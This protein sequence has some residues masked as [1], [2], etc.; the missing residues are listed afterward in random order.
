MVTILKQI[1]YDGTVHDV[2][3]LSTDTKPTEGIANG[4]TCIEIDTGKGYLFDKTGGQWIELP[5]GGA[6]VISTATGVEF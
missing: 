1:T 2:R 4:S 5:G 6:V 3:C